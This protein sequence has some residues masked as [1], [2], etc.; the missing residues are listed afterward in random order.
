MGEEGGGG[1]IKIC[2]VH[3][4]VE[5]SCRHENFLPFRAQPEVIW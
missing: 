4:R 2:V 3:G 5:K 1:S